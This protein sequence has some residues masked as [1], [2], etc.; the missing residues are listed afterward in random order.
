ML[1]QTLDVLF[2]EQIL[3][4]GGNQQGLETANNV[5]MVRVIHL[6]HAT[7]VQPAVSHEGQ[8]IMNIELCVIL[9]PFPAEG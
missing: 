5:K 2:V 1:L 4:V 3:A 6:S 9:P 7:G 8:L